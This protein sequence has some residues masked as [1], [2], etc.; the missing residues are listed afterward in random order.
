[1]LLEREQRDSPRVEYY[2][3]S[4]KMGNIFFDDKFKVKLGDFGLSTYSCN[5]L[6]KKNICGTPNYIA[7][8]V[9]SRDSYGCEV[10]VWSTGILMYH[11][12]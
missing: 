10:D 12:I 2:Q 4:I 9:I 5:H 1:M 3:C 11:N 6:L 8:E 7:P